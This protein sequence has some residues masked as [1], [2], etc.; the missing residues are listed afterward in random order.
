MKAVKGEEN[1]L[2]TEDKIGKLEEITRDIKDNKINIRS[3]NAYSDGAKAYFRLLTSNNTTTKEILK[4]FG[5]VE[6]KEVVIVDMP[7]EIGQLHSLAV[8]LKEANININYMYGTAATPKG[9]VIVVFSSDDNNKA[10][11][12]LSQ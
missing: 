9:S 2:I 11:E 7:D 6:S 8:K 5:T 4:K 3:I 10:I 1:F 12:I